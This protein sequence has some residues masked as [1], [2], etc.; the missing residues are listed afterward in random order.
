MPTS[1]EIDELVSTQSSSAYRWEKISAHD[2]VVGWRVTYLANNNS[3]ILPAACYKFGTTLI[4]GIYIWSSSLGAD[5]PFEA[6]FLCNYD[7]GFA[8][9]FNERS[10]GVPIRPVCK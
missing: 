2:D 1:E 4:Y 7:T 6:H 9:S 10:D 8:R 3:I 5:F